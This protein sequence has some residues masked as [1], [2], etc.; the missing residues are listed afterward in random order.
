M[1]KLNTLNRKNFRL[2]V[3]PLSGTLVLPEPNPTKPELVWGIIEPSN[4]NKNMPAQIMRLAS[5]WLR[6]QGSSKQWRAELL[7]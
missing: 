4:P 5:R 7:L 3:N 6:A 2:T 1:W